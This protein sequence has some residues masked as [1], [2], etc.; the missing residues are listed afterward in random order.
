M[1]CGSSK[2]RG[3]G[4]LFPKG[5]INPLKEAIVVLVVI[6]VYLICHAFAN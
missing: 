4:P 5:Q 6:I 3:F 2:G 1:S